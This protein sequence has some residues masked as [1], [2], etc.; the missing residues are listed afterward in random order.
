MLPFFYPRDRSTSIK[1]DRL[2]AP[3]MVLLNL[4]FRFAHQ[5]RFQPPPN[6]IAGGS[7]GW[8]DLRFA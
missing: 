8:D 1:S 4:S 6:L 5:S 7:E 3:S 2:V